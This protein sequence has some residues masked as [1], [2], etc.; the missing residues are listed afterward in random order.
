MELTL[1]S[2]NETN[3]AKVVE[4]AKSLDIVVQVHEV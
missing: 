1:I 4:L 3:M 2:D